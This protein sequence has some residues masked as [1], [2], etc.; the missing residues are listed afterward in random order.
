[1]CGI[2]GYWTL[3]ENA[4]SLQRALP[5]AVASLHHRG[6]D[7]AGVWHAEPGVGLG[8]AR[9]SII[10]L[11]VAGAQPMVA[12]DAEIAI[13]FNGEIYNFA[14]IAAEL[15]AKGHKLV[16]HSDT[17]VVL[18]AFREW[19]PA[20]VERFIGMFA[21]AIW[22]GPR[23]RFSLC[24][25]RVGV[26]PLYYGWDGHVL[27]FAS[28]LKALRALPHWRPE[29]DQ[30]ALGEFLQYGYIGEP[31]SIYRQVRKLPPG[32]WLRLDQGKA[33]VIERYWSLHAVVEKGP[34]TGNERDLEAELED[35]LVSAFKYRL[36]A[37]VPVGLFL[38]GGIDSSL[39]AGILKSAGVEIE[40]FT[41]GFKSAKHDESAAA[42]RVA[43]ALGF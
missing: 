28:E 38:S 23:R 8:H 41:I 39:V 43:A 15:T 3:G 35:L 33:P 2:V 42:A 40:T 5:E 26:K 18:A 22:D 29:I 25:D 34:L 31:R 20:C 36:V 1:M 17:E 9:L 30:T 32:C 12:R 27:A 11:S 24:R 10:D 13:I 7:G 16:G 37:D 6:P 14:A 21:F 4:G 19:G